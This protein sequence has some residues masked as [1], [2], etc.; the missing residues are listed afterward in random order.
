VIP[1]YL[2]IVCAL[3][4]LAATTQTGEVTP[5]IVCSETRWAKPKTRWAKPKTRTPNDPALTWGRWRVD[6]EERAR[7]GSHG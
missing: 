3:S 2:A 7:M 1:I 6:P 4:A 5:A